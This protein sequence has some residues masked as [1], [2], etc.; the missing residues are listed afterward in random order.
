MDPTK[1][2]LYGA[3]RS[4]GV[5]VSDPEIA[6]T[7][8][9]VRE[10]GDAL[11]WLLLS[12]ADSKTMRVC[13]TGEGGLDEMLSLLND[14]EAFF[15]C[16]RAQIEGAVKFYSVA[17]VGENLNGMKRGK[18][19]MHKSGVLNSFECHGSVSLEGIEGTSRALVLQ[20]IAQQSRVNECSIEI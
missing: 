20:Q 10:D 3:K 17:F 19:S 12:Y 11:N 13:G 2:E 15:G 8:E 1:K 7:W 16:V 9:K 6:A 14:D 5:D 18:A 4:S